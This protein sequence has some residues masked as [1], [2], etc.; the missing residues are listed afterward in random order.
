TDS[1]V[2]RLW[3]RALPWAMALPFIANTAGWV[4]TEMGRQPWVAYGL[5]R[6]EDGVSPAVSTL[7]VVLTLSGFTL[8]YGVLMVVTIGLLKRHIEAGPPGA[9]E[10]EVD[11]QHRTFSPLSGGY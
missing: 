8:V 7:E 10:G 2:N 5:L 6:T 11:E 1:R 9:E 4:L 3:L